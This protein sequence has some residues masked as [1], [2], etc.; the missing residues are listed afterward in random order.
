LPALP[1]LEMFDS[2]ALFAKKTFKFSMAINMF[3]QYGN[4]QPHSKKKKNTAK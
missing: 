1:Q 3:V 2:A 4:T